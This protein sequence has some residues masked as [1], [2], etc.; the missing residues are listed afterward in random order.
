ME[1]PGIDRQAAEQAAEVF[2]APGDQVLDAVDT[3]P[4]P[5]HGQQPRL[6]QRLAPY[7]KQES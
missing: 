5:A 7:A 4:A 6:Q 2:H 3:L 1:V